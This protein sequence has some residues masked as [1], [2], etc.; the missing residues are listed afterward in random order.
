[1]PATG[2]PSGQHL[3]GTTSD[4]LSVAFSP[5]C[6]RLTS[7]VGYGTIRLWD[8]YP[9]PLSDQACKRANRK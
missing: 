8:V 5:N 3:I 4:V 2:Q 6:Q 9:G 1:M 7:G